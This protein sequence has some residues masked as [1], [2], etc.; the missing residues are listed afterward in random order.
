MKVYLTAIFVAFGLAG[1]S[2]GNGVMD[3]IMTSWNGS[4]LDEVVA[5]WGYPNTQQDYGD[6]K[7]YIWSRNVSM[8]LPSTANTTGTVSS[9]GTYTAFTTFSGGGVSNWNCDRILE[10]NSDS[11]IVGTQ[12][13]GNNCPFAEAMYAKNWR[14]K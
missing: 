6:N 11:V 8:N 3:G 13:R 1:C 2:G 12:W 5:Q 14:K 4:K 9:Y 7:L 10:V